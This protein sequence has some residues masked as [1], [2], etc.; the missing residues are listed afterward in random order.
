MKKVILYFLSVFVLAACSKSGDTLKNEIFSITLNETK[1]GVASIDYAGQNLLAPDN[2]AQ[3]LFNL[4]FRNRNEGG[5]IVEFDAAK[6]SVI[7]SN[8]KKDKL[9]IDN[10]DGIISLNIGDNEYSRTKYQ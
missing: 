9:I 5:R 7:V 4:R 2:A 8:L 1:T 3:P 10:V 6:A